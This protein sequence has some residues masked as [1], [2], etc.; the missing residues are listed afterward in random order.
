MKWLNNYVKDSAIIY[1]EAI[2][3]ACKTVKVADPRSAL[4]D[5][6][7]RAPRLQKIPEVEFAIGWLNGCAESHGVTIDAVWNA[8]VI[9]IAKAGVEKI[10][11]STKKG[12]AA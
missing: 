7:L 9:A 6:D 3:E 11:R 4:V 1:V 12:R 10:G 8:A 5:T 2:L